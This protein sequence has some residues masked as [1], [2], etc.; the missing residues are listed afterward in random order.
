MA[1]NPAAAAAAAGKNASP[2]PGV[3]FWDLDSAHSHAGF[4][5]RHM[6]IANVRGEFTRLAGS[7][8]LDEKDPTCSSVHAAV[9]VASINTREADRDGHL[10]SGDFFDATRFPKIIFQ[11]KSIARDASGRFTLTGD[12]T[13]RDAT[14]AI[15][16]AV[17]E[18]TPQ[19]RDPWGKLR[20]GVS[21]RGQLNRKEFGLAWNAAIE[22]GGLLVGEQVNLSIEAEFVKR[23]G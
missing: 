11:S 22:G 19:R 6:M 8:E 7:V 4:S 14:R 20:F 17:E 1:E 18:M 21:A 15:S 2:R 23:E 12:L 3:S 13:I 5:I 10:R 9:E 16:L